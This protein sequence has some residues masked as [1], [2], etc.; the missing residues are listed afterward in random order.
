ML[1]KG[2]NLSGCANVP[3]CKTNESKTSY[4]L[5]YQTYSHEKQ[6]KFE[7]AC[8]DMTDV[9]YSLDTPPTPFFG[10]WLTVCES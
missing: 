4:M 9:L 10:L 2:G 3:E 8:K 1:N 6:Q 5:H 7:E